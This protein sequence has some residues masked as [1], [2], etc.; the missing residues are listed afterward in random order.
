VR[1]VGHAVAHVCGR[2]HLE[3][4]LGEGVRC[5]AH[6]FPAAH[7]YEVTLIGGGE[8]Q[9][10]DA[11]VRTRHFAERGVAREQE[12]IL[13]STAPSVPIAQDLYA[14]GP[15]LFERVR[16]AVLPLEVHQPVVLLC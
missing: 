1:R 2:A 3:P 12:Q 7:T 11:P 4:E 16:V 13:A 15:Y 10:V 9:D 14:R 5:A 6:V 8:L